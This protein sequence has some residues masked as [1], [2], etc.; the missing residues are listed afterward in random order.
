MKLQQISLLAL[1]ALSLMAAAPNGKTIAFSGN[2]N[3]AAPCAACHGDHFQG[4]AALHAP[5]LAG[6]SAK[7]ILARLAHYEGPSG[8]NAM[9]KQEASALSPAEAQA[10]ADYLASLPKS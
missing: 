2:G 9:M 8:H 1:A 6:L 10:V 4:N 7:F 5:A 3:G